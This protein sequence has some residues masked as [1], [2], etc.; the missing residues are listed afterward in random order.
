M[1]NENNSKR[2][3]ESI[4]IDDKSR[5][6][7]LAVILFVLFLL[8]CWALGNNSEKKVANSSF[9]ADKD[10][11]IEYSHENHD[12]ILKAI[13][14]CILGDFRADPNKIHDLTSRQ[15]EELIAYLYFRK[16]YEVHLTPAT[17]DGGKDVVAKYLMPTG[18]TIVYYI[19]CK[20]Y[21]PENSVGVGIVNQFSGAM[22]GENVHVGVIITSSK[23]SKDAKDLVQ[24]KNFRI[25][26]KDMDDIVSLL[27]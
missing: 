3:L 23:F 25:E 21:T 10:F 15:F 11:T 22:F 16:G 5:R 17:R 14:D 18:E 9:G 24:S 20:H 27:S 6:L 4:E 19:E 1:E 7:I 8:F 2:R 12:S 13:D 26:L